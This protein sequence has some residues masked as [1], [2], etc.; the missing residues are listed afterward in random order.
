MLDALSN[1][2]KIMYSAFSLYKPIFYV[3]SWE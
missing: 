1:R 2:T 3:V